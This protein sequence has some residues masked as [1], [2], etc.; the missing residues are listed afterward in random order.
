MTIKS[1]RGPELEKCTVRPQNF[2][3]AKKEFIRKSLFL[4]FCIQKSL[5]I[6]MLSGYRER[7]IDSGMGMFLTHDI[8]IKQVRTEIVQEGIERETIGP[9]SGEVL[10]VNIGVVLQ[11]GN[12]RIDKNGL[13]KSK[14][15]LFILLKAQTLL[16]CRLNKILI[17]FF[18]LAFSYLNRVKSLP[19]RNLFQI[20]IF[21]RTSIL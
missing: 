11:E 10:D 15:L 2:E 3:K 9:R 12:H 19:D 17:F 8:E 14:Y 4:A 7:M 21:I 6:E 16:S 13:L 18:L 20:K 1:V 5:N